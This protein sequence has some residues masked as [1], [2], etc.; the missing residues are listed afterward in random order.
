MSG[1]ANCPECCCVLEICCQSAEADAVYAQQLE[2]DLGCTPEEARRH[3]A[4]T[5]ARFALAPLS[6]RQV[7]AD[8][9]QM[10]RE[11]SAHE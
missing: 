9:K 10:S 5:R 2:K 7:I 4:W 6:F 3:V 11:H 1:E 8:I